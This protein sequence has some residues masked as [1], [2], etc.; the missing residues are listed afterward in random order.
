M[1]V[2]WLDARAALQGTN[3]PFTEALAHGT[4]LEKAGVV[5][6]GPA[7]VVQQIQ[8]NERQ[9][10]IQSLENAAQL[11]TDSEKKLF[12]QGAVSSLQQRR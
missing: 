10:L 5:H 12:I 7:Q 3:E 6:F 2:K 11:E 9:R 4:E 1:F 8:V